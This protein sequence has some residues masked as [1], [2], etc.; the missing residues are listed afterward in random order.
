M[1]SIFDFN[2]DGKTSLFELTVGMNLFMK[3]NDEQDKQE[4]PIL[5]GLTLENPDA[6]AMGVGPDGL[7]LE[8][9]D[10]DEDPLE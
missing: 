6:D 5:P 9:W 2:G 8:N 10:E 7:S 3:P 1:F 4:E